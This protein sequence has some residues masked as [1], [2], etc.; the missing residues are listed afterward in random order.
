MITHQPASS[1]HIATAPPV[2]SVPVR[3]KSV[4]LLAVLL[5][6]LGLLAAMALLWGHGFGWTYLGLLLGFYLL[7]AFGIT[8]GF[9][10]LFTHRAFDTYAPIRATLAIL[11]SM[12]VQG[13]LLQ[14]VAW[15]RRHHQHS[16]EEGD[17]HSPHTHEESG[18]KGVLVGLFH[19]HVGWMIWNRD[20]DDSRYVG[21]LRKDRLLL[22]IDKSFPLWVIVG[23]VAPA[24]IGGLAT[25]SWMGALLG[26]LWGGVVRVLL[27]HHVTW[28]V[29]SVC[30]IWG[31][32][33]FNSRDE[34][35][36]NLIVGVL[37]MGEGW[38]NTHHA[39]PTSARHGLSWWQLDVSYL[40]IRL[41]SA[42]GLAWDVRVPSPEAIAAKRARPIPMTVPDAI[43]KP[44]AGRARDR[45]F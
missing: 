7:T 5:P 16:D 21:D 2:H 34:S 30:H 40:L 26:F 38:H 1:Q 14:W 10:R 11:G 13:P 44:L 3:L 24:A 8:V 25:R 22:W 27:V 18:L 42:M 31:A 20:T 41:L 35:R 9:H 43:E 23:L 37:G 17:P 33:P 36:N 12:A 45:Q 15:H 39:F 32:Q 6:I 4:N 19:S 28:S 29:N